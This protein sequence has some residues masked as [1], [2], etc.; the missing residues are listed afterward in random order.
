[1]RVAS[2]DHGGKLRCTGGSNALNSLLEALPWFGHD[3]QPAALF[4]AVC[5]QRIH[6]ALQ[7]TRIV[8][9]AEP[10]QFQ[11]FAGCKLRTP[12]RRKNR[13]LNDPWGL[14]AVLRHQLRHA[15]GVDR[16]GI[17]ETQRIFI[18]ADHIRRFLGKRI[19]ADIEDQLASGFLGANAA[20]QPVCRP[21]IEKQFADDA[22]PHAAEISSS[23]CRRIIRRKKHIALSRA[24]PGGRGDSGA[25]SGAG[26]M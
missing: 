10:Q 22:Q 20:C 8:D 13:I 14:C 11:H 9:V 2:S 26:Q 3:G 21:H 4:C 15:C 24:Q 7:I 16:D 25:Q 19:I 1:M 12:R 23:N 6:H 18:E 5:N 17:R